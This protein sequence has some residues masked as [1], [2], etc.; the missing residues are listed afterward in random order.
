[1]K[2]AKK[3]KREKAVKKMRNVAKNNI[4]NKPIK[5]LK[6]SVRPDKEESESTSVSVIHGE[7]I[8]TVYINLKEL[9]SK[10]QADSFISNKEFNNIHDMDNAMQ[11]GLV[12]RVLISKLLIYRSKNDVSVNDAIYCLVPDGTDTTWMNVLK[13]VI[14]PFLKKNNI[15]L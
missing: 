12:N 2:L 9:Y 15:P 10:E 6:V 5:D 3:K 1:M 4:S 14:I 13:L 7:I 8:D 11:R